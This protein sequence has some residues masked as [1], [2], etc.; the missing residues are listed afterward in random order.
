MQRV[1]RLQRPDHDL[2]AVDPALRVPADDVDAVDLDPV[3]RRSRTP[4]PRSVPRTI[5]RHSGNASP[6]NTCVAAA[7]YFVVIALPRCGVWTT[8]DWKTT[9]SASSASS[10][11]GSRDLA[12]SQPM[13]DRSRASCGFLGS[14]GQQPT[15]PGA[16]HRRGALR[17]S[18]RGETWF[19]RGR[20]QTE[21]PMS[22][23]SLD[24]GERIA[25]ANGLETLLPDLRRCPAIPPMLLIM[26]LG[27]QMIV[28]DDEF[29]A[30]AGGARLSRRPLRQSRRRQVEQDRR[31]RRRRSPRRCSPCKPGDRL[32]GALSAL[33]H[34]GRRGRPDGRARESAKAHIVGAS[35]GGMIAQE[36]GDPISR[37]ACGR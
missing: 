4:A 14:G 16:C 32:A 3:E 11:A 5:R 37:S 34:G 33:R 36:V 29:C 26:G 2:E 15:A 9:S 21:V 19:A 23:V 17:L 13:G 1:D 28:W 6:P 30:A 22:A 35:M 7:R 8:G 20:N 24:P 31:R 18:R 27:A 25:K 12:I 10:P